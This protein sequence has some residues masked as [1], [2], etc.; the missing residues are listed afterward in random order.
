MSLNR[1]PSPRYK[2]KAFS[3][4]LRK[5]SFPASPIS[6]KLATYVAD[7]FDKFLAGKSRTLNAAFGLQKKRGVPGWP[8]A[9]LKMA[10]E[11]YALRKSGKSWSQV[12]GELE[13]LGYKDTDLSTIK[14]TLKEFR[15]HLMEKELWQSLGPELLQD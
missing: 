12:Q 2:I 6:V 14:R 10:K 13:R 15:L 1:G 9:R 5:L 11:I 8:K 7:A 4:Q 3:K